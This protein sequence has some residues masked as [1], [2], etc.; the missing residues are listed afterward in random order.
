M[1]YQE[2]LD[3]VLGR[4]RTLTFLDPETK[5]VDAAEVE[6]ATQ[7]SLLEISDGW[8]LDTFIRLNTDM[9]TTVAGVTHYAL[10]SD[11]GRLRIPRDEDESGIYLRNPHSTQPVPLRYRDHEDW[12]R[13]QTTTQSQPSYFTIS[14]NAVL[15]LDPPPDSNGGVDYTIQGVYIRS[16]ESLDLNDQLL[17]THPTA[18]IATTLARLAIDK[19]AAQGAVLVAERDKQ[20][21][22]LVNNQAR[23]R[24]QF[25][26]RHFTE[27]GLRRWRMH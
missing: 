14:H 27:R 26:P 24:Q 4:C 15:L 9:G 8:D 25:R 23:V 13:K 17:V 21:S 20:L 16:I 11:F 19:G 5:Q 7:M 1:R 12:F 22:K 6:L 10:P 2:Y 18:L 3:I